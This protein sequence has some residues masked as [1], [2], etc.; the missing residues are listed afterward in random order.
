M[1]YILVIF[2]S[3]F[4][5]FVVHAQNF[6][7]LQKADILEKIASSKW[8]YEQFVRLKNNAKAD[9]IFLLY[10]K[11]IE[12]VKNPLNEFKSF[13]KIKLKRESD[14]L[15]EIRIP[16][17]YTD[18]IDRESNRYRAIT[19]A[20]FYRV[21]KQVF[22]V[23]DKFELPKDFRTVKG[24][25]LDKYSH[26]S[27][28]YTSQQVENAQKYLMKNIDFKRKQR[29]EILKKSNEA[30]VVEMREYLFYEGLNEEN[31]AF[32]KWAFN[33]IISNKTIPLVVWR[34]SFDISIGKPYEPR[35]RSPHN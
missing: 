2:L 9:S 19:V 25:N 24:I 3:I 15:S 14:S 13:I 29:R 27:H 18:G 10:K 4:R 1:R 22:F 21:V 34:K 32:L 28:K 35:D 26:N 5:L 23:E 12:N 11:Q 31:I 33:D 30:Q 16:Y 8:E 6:S 7:D 17:M 20:D